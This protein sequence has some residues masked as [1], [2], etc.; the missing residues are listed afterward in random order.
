MKRR[1]FLRFMG[2]STA[3]TV[4]ST[5]LAKIP[6]AESQIILLDKPKD[7]MLPEN[8]KYN[9][10]LEE[11]DF[12]IKNVN[13]ISYNRNMIEYS[14]MSKTMVDDS[15]SYTDANGLIGDISIS[16]E[17]IFLEGNLFNFDIGNGTFAFDLNIEE[18][19]NSQ[20]TYLLR[21]HIN[22]NA[23]N[24]RKFQM[25]S[26]EITASSKTITVANVHAKEIARKWEKYYAN[27]SV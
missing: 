14:V 20:E 1:E 24:G 7:I 17:A 3:A 4:A 2:V 11:V 19:K 10:L 12:I 15:N 23:L 6:E 25:M 21:D 18:M 22:L 9:G 27:V 5:A 13:E 26:Y 16:L 8:D